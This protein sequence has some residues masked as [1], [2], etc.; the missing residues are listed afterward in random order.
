MKTNGVAK[1]EA[2]F[3]NTATKDTYGGQETSYNITVALSDAEASKLEDLGV[4][5]KDYTKDDGTVVRQKKFTSNFETR[6][7][8]GEG[9]DAVV[10]QNADGSKKEVPFGSKVNVWY[11][12]GDNHPQYGVKAYMKAVRITEE[13][14][15]EAPD[16]F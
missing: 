16:E 2:V 1:G 7:L 13:A 10:Y 12:L 14:E 8:L 3:C 4:K 5:L 11:E 15:G 9:E 6:V